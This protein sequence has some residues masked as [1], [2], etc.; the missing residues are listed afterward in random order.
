MVAGCYSEGLL[1]KNVSQMLYKSAVMA[2]K[3]TILCSVTVHSVPL[4]FVCTMDYVIT[5]SGLTWVVYFS[6]ERSRLV[7]LTARLK[8]Q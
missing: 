6:L 7:I 2:L 1:V 4:L 5:C 3:W 8:T